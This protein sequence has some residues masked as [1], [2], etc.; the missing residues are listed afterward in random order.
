[1]VEAQAQV[2]VEVEEDLGVGAKVHK[3]AA[4]HPPLLV[5]RDA[6]VFLPSIK[7][8]VKAHETLKLLSGFFSPVSWSGVAGSLFRIF[9]VSANP[10]LYI[11]P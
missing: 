3:L 6:P 10:A 4:S 5:G 8:P 1:M 2:L 11:Y 9:P 7:P